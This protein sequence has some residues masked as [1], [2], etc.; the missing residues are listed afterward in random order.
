MEHQLRLPGDWP[1]GGHHPASKPLA[2]E[3]LESV[4]VWLQEAEV[5]AWIQTTPPAHIAVGVHDPYAGDDIREDFEPV[6]GE[7]PRGDIARWLIATVRHHY[8]R[9]RP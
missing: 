6:N 1:V 2:G 7:W 3:D 5:N 9:G 4:L 8:P